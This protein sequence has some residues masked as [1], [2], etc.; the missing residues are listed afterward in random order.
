[1]TFWT[2]PDVVLPHTLS[3]AYPL[4]RARVPS[5]SGRIHYLR[6][7]GRD[8][9]TAF[10]LVRPDVFVREE[11]VERARA[12]FDLAEVFLPADARRGLADPCRLRACMRRASSCHFSSGMSSSMPLAVTVTVLAPMILLLLVL[13][14]RLLA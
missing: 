1:M 10:A 12:R 3:I 11:A 8:L 9:G 14:S 7:A 5:L 13:L 6:R 4:V 2:L